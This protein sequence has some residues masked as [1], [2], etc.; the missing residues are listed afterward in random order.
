MTAP[1]QEHLEYKKPKSIKVTATTQQ[2][3]CNTNLTKEDKSK[4][5]MKT[6]SQCVFYTPVTL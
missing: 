5:M 2:S 3:K 6:P 4:C 1:D